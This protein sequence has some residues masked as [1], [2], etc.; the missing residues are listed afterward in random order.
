MT[1]EDCEK[2][3]VP[4]FHKR[5]SDHL[6]MMFTFHLTDRE[7]EGA[8]DTE[9][10]AQLGRV[11]SGKWSN[12]DKR[13]C[14]QLSQARQAERERDGNQLLATGVA[15]DMCEATRPVEQERLRRDRE[16]SDA[17]SHCFWTPEMKA[18]RN[19]L[20]RAKR[21]DFLGAERRRLA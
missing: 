8:A 18:V 17:A 9:A 20:R 19:H 4:N 13:Q 5:C 10:T 16:A 3:I 15:E 7:V 6:P 14:K 12:A 2:E 21:R 1:S 11:H